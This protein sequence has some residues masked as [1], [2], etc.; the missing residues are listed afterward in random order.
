[1]MAPTIAYSTAVR[2]ERESARGHAREAGMVGRGGAHGHA[3]QAAH[4]APQAD[5]H[6]DVILA[7]GSAGSERLRSAIVQILANMLDLHLPAQA[8]AERPRLHHHRGTI[9]AEGGTALEVALALEAAGYDVN[10]WPTTDLFFGGA[11]VA[12]RRALDEG[13]AFDGGGD[14]RRGGAAIVV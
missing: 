3:Q 6:A 2:A 9:H 14:P 4:G 12:V 8:A 1:M 5:A 10:R 7:L 13:V 11:Q